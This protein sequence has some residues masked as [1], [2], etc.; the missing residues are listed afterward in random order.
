M[1]GMADGQDVAYRLGLVRLCDNHGRDVEHLELVEDIV[2]VYLLHR[3]ADSKITSDILAVR[4]VEH[5]LELNVQLVVP[6][7]SSYRVYQDK[8]GIAGLLQSL[9]EL[10]LVVGSQNGDV[11]RLSEAFHLLVGPYSERIH[12]DNPDLLPEL[13]GR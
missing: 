13:L 2:D 6:G 11:Q 3:G 4:N 9:E 12:G 8:L 10:G 5:G 1:L 7:T